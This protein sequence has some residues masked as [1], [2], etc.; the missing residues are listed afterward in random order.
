METSK[1][2]N[3]YKQCSDWTESVTIHETNW[4]DNI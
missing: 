4:T 2:S 3:V 1:K